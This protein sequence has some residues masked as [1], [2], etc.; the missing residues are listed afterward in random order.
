MSSP[1]AD[2]GETAPVEVPAQTLDPA[3][4]RALV[5]SGRRN[6]A[7]RLYQQACE[8][9]GDADIDPLLHYWGLMALARS[10]FILEAM[11]RYRATGLD[12]VDTRDFRLL[13]ARL[14]KD[15]YFQTGRRHLWMVEQAGDLYRREYD[16]DRDGFPGI[17]AAFLAF[18]ADDTKTAHDLAGEIVSSLSTQL[19]PNG[20]A[21]QNLPIGK[22]YGYLTLIEALYLSGHNDRA[23]DLLSDL[24]HN[25]AA[26]QGAID[27][28]LRQLRRIYD[29]TGLRM[30]NLPA[31]RQPGLMRF[32]GEIF[33]ITGDPRGHPDAKRRP[34]LTESEAGRLR[35]EAKALL[36]SRSCQ[37]AVGAL[38]AGA[39]LI[40]A[41]TALEAGCALQAVLPSGV[42][43][44]R[45]RSVTPFGPR[46]EHAFE[47]CLA[48]PKTTLTCL[49]GVLSDGPDLAK[50]Y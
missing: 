1:Q 40:I 48:H 49:S 37:I 43:D 33:Q 22:A 29:H 30:P 16:R 35:I 23:T 34:L 3:G 18:V 39:D 26:P 50:I 42:D 41:E 45:A 38:A 6:E 19:D 27:N 8:G 25:A 4:L 24:M 47:T 15:L 31:R 10:G 28:F 7:Y 32:C 5:E 20:L 36:A 12:H 9:V 11:K 14:L 44:F 17:N 2:S 21:D 46:W 13:P